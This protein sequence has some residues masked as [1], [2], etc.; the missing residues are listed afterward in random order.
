[1]WNG[2]QSQT[3]S[4]IEKAKKHP[5]WIVAKRLIQQAAEGN[6]NDI[7]SGADFYFNPKLVLP[8]WANKFEKTKKIG[9]HVFYKHGNVPISKFV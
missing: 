8:K 1:M 5:K 3:D 6:L 2:K 4:V 9:N 7:T